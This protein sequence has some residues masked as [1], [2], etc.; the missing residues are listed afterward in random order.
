M[1]SQITVAHLSA[2][3][4]VGPPLTIWNPLASV[5]AWLAKD[6]R[7]A[8]SLHGMARKPNVPPSGNSMESVWTVIPLTI[9][10]V[11]KNYEWIF[12]TKLSQS[13]NPFIADT[14][15]AHSYHLR[16]RAENLMPIKI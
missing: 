7:D 4:F 16:S 6:T 9:L 2:L 1:R 10:S 15:T 12:L 8:T 11:T 5:K 14:S 3:L 13:I